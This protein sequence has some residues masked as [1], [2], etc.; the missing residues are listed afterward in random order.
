[1]ISLSVHSRPRKQPER[2]QPERDHQPLVPSASS[3]RHAPPLVRTTPRRSALPV[4]TALD[5]PAAPAP[6]PPPRDPPAP[7]LR[8]REWS[9]RSCINDAGAGYAP[10]QIG[11]TRA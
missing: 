10:C 3:A 2:K 11:G 1:M 6:Q 8:H 7:A 5:H 4:A 9:T